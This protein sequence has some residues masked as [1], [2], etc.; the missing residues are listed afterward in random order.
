MSMPNP[1]GQGSPRRGL[2]IPLTV[3]AHAARRQRIWRAERAAIPGRRIS[4]STAPR[5]PRAQAG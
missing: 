5:L 4:A 1:D 2:A 3:D